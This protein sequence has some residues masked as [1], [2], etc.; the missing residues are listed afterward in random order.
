MG[1]FP[2]LT[3]ENVAGPIIEGLRAHGWDILRV[4]DVFG[5]R[6]DDPVVFG[7]AVEQGRVL[8][9]TDT[10]TLAV[11]KAWLVQGRAFRLVYWQQGRSQHLPV[12]RFLK[13]FEALA[14]KPDAFA[15]CIEYLPLGG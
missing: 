15:A 6:S 3:D 13:A 8:V 5:E 11:G 2:L 7:Y 10:D 4:V 1:P 12:G 14:A 9:S